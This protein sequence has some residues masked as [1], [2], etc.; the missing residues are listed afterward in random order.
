MSF[1]QRMFK[2]ILPQ[3]WAASMEAN[4]RSWMVR[5]SCGFAKSV[6][7]WGGIR[8]KATGHTVWYRTC[9]QCGQSSWHTLTH[10]PPVPTPTPQG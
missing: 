4:S 7:D 3:S 5:C 2:A 9:P 6:W 10:E 8:W 1:M